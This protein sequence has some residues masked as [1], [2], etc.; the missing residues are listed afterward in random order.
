MT[1][2]LIVDDHPIVRT[3]LRSVLV[4]EELDV[5]GEAASG[6]EA[7]TLTEHLSP[8][9]VLC[10]LRLGDG[11][12]GIETTKELRALTNPPIVVLLTTFDR[13]AELF[14]ALHAGASG[15]LL[16][17]AEPKDIHDGILTAARGEMA[18]APELTTRVLRGISAPLP[19]LTEREKDVLRL[20]A[21]G[22]SNKEI[23]KQLFVSE[24]TTKSHLN[25]IFNKLD[26]DSRSKAIYVAQERGLL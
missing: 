7:I 17:D 16:K 13:D 24:A 21:T 9:V 26:V 1:T 23:S 20:A 18:L 4:S 6:V 5:V 15:Y 2:V 14:G 3:G 8:D 12:D 22:A 11:M 25:N 19:E 10:D